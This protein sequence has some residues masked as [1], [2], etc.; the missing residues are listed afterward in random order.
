MALSIETLSLRSRFGR[1]V[2]LLFVLCAL[3][4]ILTAW[5][6]S[7]AHV[8]QSS[9]LRQVAQLRDFSATYG[10]SMLQRLEAADAALRTIASLEKVPQLGQTAAS[11]GVWRALTLVSARDTI[12]T[13][14]GR[15]LPVLDAVARRHLADGDSALA[16]T[17]AGGNVPRVFIV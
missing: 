7:F 5:V 15:L 13:R 4:P 11:S 17:P 6:F 16:I 10:L 8:Q 1:R 9:R 2:L 12:P 3:V 14:D